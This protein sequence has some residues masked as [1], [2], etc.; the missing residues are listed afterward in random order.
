MIELLLAFALAT[1]VPIGARQA[2]ALIAFPTAGRTAIVAT[3]IVA[4]GAMAVD[5]GVL[6][7]GLVAPWTTVTACLVVASARHLRRTGRDR[8]PIGTPLG[9]TVATTFLLV[10]AI[11]LEIDRVGVRPF[12]LPTVLVLLTPVH[13]HVA[14]FV[15]T[16][17]GVLARRSARN[18]RTRRFGTASVAALIV[19]TPLTAAGI[20]TSP[21]VG[22][23]GAIL[24]AGGGLGIAIAQIA[25][26]RGLSDDLGRIALRI[27]GLA[28]FVSLPLAVAY[29]TGS[30][31]GIVGLG[32]P[33]MAAVHGT[34]TVF[35]FPI[36]SMLGWA[37]VAR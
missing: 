35:G 5:R 34:A 18:D 36:P 25:A 3:A 7:A 14:G 24:V 10:G 17:A 22:W 12:G 11:W 19:G 2:G 27:G 26:T 21:L 15:L 13:F 28:L 32:V 29:A 31:F 6:A 37:R 9:I 16:L 33:A 1:A 23:I 20:L 30:A 4:A 8:R